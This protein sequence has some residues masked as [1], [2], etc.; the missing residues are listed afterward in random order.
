MSGCI[1]RLAGGTGQPDFVFAGTS[2]DGT[3]EELAGTNWMSSR[4]AMYIRIL[5]VC[6][7]ALVVGWQSVVQNPFRMR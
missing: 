4:S 6:F 5:G 3:R 2:T 1:T 7:Y